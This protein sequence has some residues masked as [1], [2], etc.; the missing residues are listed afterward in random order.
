M[1]PSALIINIARGLIIHQEDL[2]DALDQNLIRGAILDVT[3]PEPLPKTHKLW[4]YPNVIITPHNSNLSHLTNQRLCNL[5]IKTIQ[6]IKEN[7]IPNN[8]I[9]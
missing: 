2:M 7:K 6:S 1:K 9:V 3:T 8:Q 4:T 5:F